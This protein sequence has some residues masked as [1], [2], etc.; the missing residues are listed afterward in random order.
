[1]EILGAGEYWMSEEEHWQETASYDEVF[2]NTQ[3]NLE[4]LQKRD[5]KNVGDQFNTTEDTLKVPKPIWDDDEKYPLDESYF[6][7]LT[8]DYRYYMRG[9]LKK[10][11]TLYDEMLGEVVSMEH[12]RDLKE[13]Y[14]PI[15]KL[16][17]RFGSW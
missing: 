12:F 3:E 16:S 9:S 4:D 17:Y 11:K 8:K 10:Y 7:Y 2:I 15:L 5:A 13:W 14:K 1:M 6:E